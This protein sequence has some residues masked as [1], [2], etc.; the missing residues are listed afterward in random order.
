MDQ[1]RQKLLIGALAVVALGAGSYY[2]FFASGS[3]PAVNQ[4]DTGPIVVKER[5]RAETKAAPSR[6]RDTTKASA[7][8]APIE[9]RTRA[10]PVEREAPQGKTRTRGPAKVQKK[11][12]RPIAG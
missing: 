11:D 6:T 10:E 2:V 5:Q 8:Q 1:N 4:Q 7:P 3:G 12:D 9:G